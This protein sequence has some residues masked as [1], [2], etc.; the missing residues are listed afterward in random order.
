MALNIWVLQIGEPL[1]TRTV[2]EMRTALLCRQL[3]ARG[4]AVLWWASAFDHFS[5]EWLF[6]DDARSTIEP[7]LEILALRGCGYAKN[8]SLRRFVDHRLIARK[9]RELA[10]AEPRPDVIVASMPSHD[11]AYEAA[12]FAAKRDIPL[13]VDV[14]DQWPDVI[15]E[16]LPGVLRGVGRILLNRDFGM[17]RYVFSRAAS[18]TSMMD[19]MLHWAQARGGQRS[20]VA[21][22]VFYLGARRIE[23]PATHAS[24][25]LE[26]LGSLQSTEIISFVGTFGR[27]YHP[28]IVVEAARRMQ[29]ERAH[30]VLGGRGDYFDDVRALSAGLD[31]VTLTGWLDES[32]IAYLMSRSTVGIVPCTLET[33]ALPNKVFTYL[34]GGIPVISSLQGDAKALLMRENIGRYYPPNDLD[35]LVETIRSLVSAPRVVEEMARNVKRFFANAL[36]ADVIYERFA[37]HVE[38][39]ARG[40]A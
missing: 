30:F 2:R 29:G 6:A 33:E 10:K 3:I 36:D 27:Y 28:G 23:V 1:P 12:V 38:Q 40:W 31:N 34:A 26:F 32:E 11:L 39:V 16:R 19:S 4:H 20:T 5:K 13:V 14:R 21:D 37:T 9:F 24:P 35:A 7:S 8:V 22:R 18:L 17:V 25:K 15:V